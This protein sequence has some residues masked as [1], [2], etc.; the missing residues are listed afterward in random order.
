MRLAARSGLIATTLAIAAIAATRGR[1]RLTAV[2]RDAI[3]SQ[4]NKE[5]LMSTLPS[6]NASLRRSITPIV[7]TALLACT[8]PAAA[9]AEPPNPCSAHTV[10]SLTPAR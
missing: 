8:A 5:D 2:H 3:G 1:A 10:A 4:H 7:L 9:I 6:I